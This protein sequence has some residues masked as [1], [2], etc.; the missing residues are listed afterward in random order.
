VPA[1]PHDRSLNHDRRAVDRGDRALSEPVADQR[2]RNA[3]AAADLEEMIVG[4][5]REPLNGPEQAW[6]HS[7]GHG[8]RS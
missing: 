3:A 5:D 1:V 2:D 7:V 6:R 8:R 4:L